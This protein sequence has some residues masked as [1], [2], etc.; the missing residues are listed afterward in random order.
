[1]RELVLSVRQAQAKI[2]TA[3]RAVEA[4]KRV[5]ITRRGRKVAQLIRS[6]EPPSRLSR[7]ER[8]LRRLEAEGK[9]VCK[10]HGPIPPYTPPATRIRGLAERVLRDRR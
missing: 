6:T 10:E 5:F 1:M 4:G 7:E 9:I 3:L 8:I 2:G